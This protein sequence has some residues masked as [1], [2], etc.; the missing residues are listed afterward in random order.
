MLLMLSLRSLAGV[1]ILLLWTD[2]VERDCISVGAGL[3]GET[4]GWLGRGR[5]LMVRLFVRA[6]LVGLVKLA[7]DFDVGGSSWE[8]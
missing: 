7:S 5:K 6:K 8:V 2:V 3:D 4:L 1:G